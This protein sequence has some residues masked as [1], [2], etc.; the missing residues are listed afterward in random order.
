MGPD[1]LNISVETVKKHINN[2]R[3]TY[4]QEKKKIGASQKTGG[5]IY[6]CRSN[7]QLFFPNADRR[8]L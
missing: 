1:I 5:S 3:S 2:L 4:N 8:V 6:F 7:Y